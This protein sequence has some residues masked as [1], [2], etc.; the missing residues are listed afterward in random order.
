MNPYAIIGSAAGGAVAGGFNAA[1]DRGSNVRKLKRLGKGNKEL[2]GSVEDIYGDT[3]SDV[4]IAYDNILQGYDPRGYI[5]EL[6]NTDYSQ[7][8]I[9]A[10]GEFQ[11]DD[12]AETQKRL[13]PELDEIINRQT[14]TLEGS[15]ANR[16]QLFSGATGKKLARSAADITAREWGEAANRAQTAR[17]NKYQEF[18]DRFDNIVKQNQFNMGLDR[19]RMADRG[20]AFDIQSSAEQRK[21]NELN[22]ARDTRNQNML[23]LQSEE[24]QIE[25]ERQGLPGRWENLVGGVLSGAVQ[26]VS[27]L[28]GA[29]GGLK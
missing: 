5:D 13:N 20:S 24:A 1:V 14:Q 6:Q 11:W 7:Y 28:G 3:R 2:Q 17:T 10:P 4:E 29:T 9:Q 12:I 18:I 26:G 27:A 16:G 15:A 23:Q 19:T 25:A 8:R 21:R 22:T